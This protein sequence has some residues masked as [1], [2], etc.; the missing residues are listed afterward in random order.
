MQGYTGTRVRPGVMCGVLVPMI[1]Q[2]DKTI[3]V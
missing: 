2:S 1:I 3:L